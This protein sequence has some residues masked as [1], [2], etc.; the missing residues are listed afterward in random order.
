M[1]PSSFEKAGRDGKS[2]EAAIE[3]AGLR[4]NAGIADLAKVAALGRDKRWAEMLSHTVEQRL[5]V[6]EVFHPFAPSPADDVLPAGGVLVGH[7]RLA[8]GSLGCPVFLPLELFT[9]GFILL[10]TTGSGK[11]ALM[12]S[13]CDQAADNGVVWAFDREG[14]AEVKLSRALRGRKFRYMRVRDFRRNLLQP[15]PGETESEMI[16]RFVSVSRTELA[17]GDGSESLQAQHVKSL[18]EEWSAL[19]KGEWPTVWHLW[20]RLAQ[21]KSRL[22][23]RERGYLEALLNRFSVLLSI[24]G[25]VYDCTRG[26]DMSVLADQSI[27]FD[28][29][30]LSDQLH[31]FFVSD[32]V[33]C[34]MAIKER[35]PSARLNLVAVDEM[36]RYARNGPAWDPWPPYLFSVAARTAR[37]RGIGLL[38]ADQVPSSIPTDVMS[39]MNT[40]LVLR[41]ND[42]RDKDAV[43][44][45]L[46]LT[47]DQ[48]TW[49]SEMPPRTAVMHSTVYP[50]PFVVALPE[51][52][53]A[54]P[55]DGEELLG[56]SKEFAAELSFEPR[57]EEAPRPKAQEKANSTLPPKEILDYMVAIERDPFAAATDRDRALGLTAYK[58]VQLRKELEQR[59]LARPVR[60]SLGKRG[61][62]LLLL[63]ILEPGKEMLRQLGVGPSEHRG[64]GGF[65]HR[66]W[67]HM[68]KRQLDETYAGTEAVI[69]DA[70]TG[71]AVDVAIEVAGRKIAY[72]ICVNG[73]DKE[74]TNIAKDEGYD[75][76]VVTAADEETLSRI[77]AKAETELAEPDL[78][79]V[80]YI[81]LG[82]LIS[83]RI[84]KHQGLQAGDDGDQRQEE[85]DK[86][87]GKNRG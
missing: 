78:R 20:R 7:V 76:V 85:D 52:E 27:V 31:R 45:S 35:R 16:A 12:F 82:D 18:V 23:A 72:E 43:A 62:N 86:D 69:E 71:R 15:L 77:R 80:S 4:G 67:Q 32:M 11:S 6:A 26:Y 17:L 63:E 8:D 65:V 79:K 29:S 59:G 36:S 61:K 68:L 19:R 60:V 5:A 38:F 25:D 48:M 64:K 13:I 41:Q 10:G 53:Y 24:M 9:L 42:G 33:A 46:G 39:N 37:K 40:R 56:L 58:G 44:K 57:R 83:G 51:V 50:R 21:Q 84:G 2:L 75:Q 3:E 1:T 54:P 22:D 87:D 49:L 30:G 55:L 47:R 14:D 73:V 28:C 34:L 70:S 66:F 81:T 74:L